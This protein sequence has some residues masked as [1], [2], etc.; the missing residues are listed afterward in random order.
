MMQGR[1]HIVRSISWKYEVKKNGATKEEQKLVP[2]P[3]WQ[4]PEYEAK[5]NGATKEEQKT[6]LSF[7]NGW[8]PSRTGT[9][10]LSFTNWRTNTRCAPCAFLPSTYLTV[11]GYMQEESG[12]PGFAFAGVKIMSPV[13]NPSWRYEVKKNGATKEEEK[14]IPTAEWQ[15]PESN[16]D[17]RVNT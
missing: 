2:K 5:K 16:G 15:D 1:M 12:P 17:L 9:K 7:M 4:D 11:H 6:P 3:A 10:G 13:R 14:S 8:T